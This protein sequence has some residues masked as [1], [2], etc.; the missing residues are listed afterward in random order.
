MIH[1]EDKTKWYKDGYVLMLIAFP[2]AAVI[3]GIITTILAIQ[4]DDGLVVDDYYKHGLEI[5]RT[6][7]R[8]RIAVD[9]GL[10]MSVQLDKQ[11]R[12]LRVNLLAADYFTY[13]NKLDL[14]F[15]HA[16]RKG[17]DRIVELDR[18][19]DQHYQSELPDLID[20]N[21]YIQLE[22]DQWRLIDNIQIIQ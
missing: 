11:S 21:W 16:T 17:F 1:K 8:D 3:G 5:N 13:P 20:G 4:S 19:G 2:L 12:L 22:T 14:K 7:E 6:L 9:M 18:V 10:E 15:L